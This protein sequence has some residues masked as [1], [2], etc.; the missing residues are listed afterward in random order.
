VLSEG[1]NVVGQDPDATGFA[2]VTLAYF[3]EKL[4]QNSGQN[5]SLAQRDLSCR[6]SPGVKS[7]HSIG[8]SVVIRFL[9]PTAK[10]R[11][12]L[13]FRAREPSIKGE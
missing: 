1:A 7:T 4:A 12:R 6:L 3:P 2:G 13:D 9:K 8:N 5:R 10:R 11:Q